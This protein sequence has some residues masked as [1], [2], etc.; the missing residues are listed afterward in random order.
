MNEAASRILSG[1]LEARTGQQLVMSRRWRIETAL[2]PLIRARGLGDLDQLITLL[3]SGREEELAERVVEALLNN[4]T[5]FFRDRTAFD[6]LVNGA[7][8]RLRRARGERKRLSIWCAGCSTGQEVYSL[9]MKVADDPRWA[10]WKL[11]IIGTD[12]SR[13]AIDQAKRG[14]YSNFEVQRGL[15][16]AQMLRWFEEK[17]PHQWQA[18]ADLRHMVRFQVHNLAEAPPPSRGAFDVILCR[19]VLLYFSEEV[20]RRVFATLAKA[21]ASDASLMLGAGETALGQTDSFVPD[22][23]L[24]GLYLRKDAEAVNV[25]RPRYGSA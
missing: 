5:Y 4:E 7:M 20:R 19:N 18:R 16:V 23:E 21:S 24:R 9:A 17:S 11:E 8:E 3:V 6:L 1:L 14:T 10:G 13:A 25:R 2:Q 22:P 12:V 15:P